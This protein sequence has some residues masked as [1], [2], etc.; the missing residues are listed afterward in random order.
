MSDFAALRTNMVDTQVR[1]SDVTKLSVIDA[2]LHVRR[3][4]FVPAERR[5][6]AY[7]GEHLPLAPGRVLLDPRTFAKTLDA[8][9][10]RRGALVLYVGA[11]MGYGPAIVA[12]IA[13]AVVA[14]EEDEALLTEAEANLAA[15]EIHNV[16]LHA[17]PLTEGAP[18]HGPFDVILI[19]G[20]VERVPDALIDQLAENGRIGSLFARGTLGTVKIGYKVDGKVTWRDSFHGGAPVLP[21]FAASPTFSL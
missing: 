6:T 19:E 14:V 2:M 3:E 8:L 5:A 1:P 9:D 16:V 7:M 20:G 18:K 21:G 4:A 11:G 10:I 12:R 17:A 13:E 15:E